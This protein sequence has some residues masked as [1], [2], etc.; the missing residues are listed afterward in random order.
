MQRAYFDLTTRQ[1]EEALG[2]M[3]KWVLQA[4]RRLGAPSSNN[5]VFD[6]DVNVYL[7]HLLTAV[8]DP[9]Y[10]AL[11]DRYVAWH[12]VDVFAHATQT[13]L[14]QLKSLIYRLNADHLL[15]IVSVF[16]H[17][18]LDA[19]AGSAG[20]TA[21]TAYEGYGQ[22]Y[23]HFAAAY[24]KQHASGTPGAGDVLDKLADDFTKYASVLTEVRQDYFHFLEAVSGR[25]FTQLLT[26][27]AAEERQAHLQ[28]LRDA[29]L[30]AYSRWRASPTTDEQNR[31]TDA[32]QALQQA[33]PTFHYPPVA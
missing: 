5:P 33:D 26:E 7:A 2:L 27:V 4:R 32:A 11:C 10:R 28:Q 30:D 8:I 23:Y 16:H 13:D 15:L 3:V 22:T 24:A 21:R 17:E 12:D 1:Q 9:R 25:H 6:E 29:F 20:V 14:P 31:L 19:P 18:A